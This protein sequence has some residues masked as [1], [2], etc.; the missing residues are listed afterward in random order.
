MEELVAFAGAR[1]DHEAV[2]EYLM[3]VVVVVGGAR[4]SRGGRRGR[5]YLVVAAY[6]FVVGETGVRGR[7]TAEGLEGCA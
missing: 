6:I 5:R 7:G 3:Q 2:L 1:G 4:R